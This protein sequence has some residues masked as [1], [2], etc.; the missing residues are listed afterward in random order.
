MLLPSLGPAP[1]GRPLP[2][3]PTLPELSTLNCRAL[4]KPPPLSA[5][6]LS[7]PRAARGWET[8]PKA[9]ASQGGGLSPGPGWMW[10]Q[11]QAQQNCQGQGNM[12]LRTPAGF[13]GKAHQ[14]A[15]LS[16]PGSSSGERAWFGAA[17]SPPRQGSKRGRRGQGVPGPGTGK[18]G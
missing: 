10:G 18:A 17:G 1:Q 2:A 15:C 3:C 11:G 6:W 14:E 13:V 5:V 16:G 9:L 4:P 12:L 8:R 7:Q